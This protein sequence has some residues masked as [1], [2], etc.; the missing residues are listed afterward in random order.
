MQAFQRQHSLPSQLAA[1]LA[2]IAPVL[3]ASLPGGPVFPASGPVPV[4][5]ITRA[6]AL[7]C[8]AA[9][10]MA[11]AVCQGLLACCVSCYV[12]EHYRVSKFHCVP[13]ATCELC[14]GWGHV[15]SECSRRTAGRLCWKCMHA[16]PPSEVNTS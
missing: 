4:Q 8:M 3:P 15:R 5:V 10:P 14:T 6:R 12:A 11:G 9:E 2:A 13:P 7:S 16:E 1:G